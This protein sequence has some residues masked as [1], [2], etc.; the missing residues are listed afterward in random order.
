MAKIALLFSGQIRNINPRLFN[1]GLRVFTKYHTADIYLSY[2]DIAGKS[3]NHSRKILENN[4]IKNFDIQKYLKT[5]FKGYDI[6]KEKIV[7]FTT[8]SKNQDQITSLIFS[9]FKLNKGFFKIVKIKN[10]R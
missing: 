9:E 6:K 10:K 2:W 3:G 7:I 4:S 1:E 8:S 5:A